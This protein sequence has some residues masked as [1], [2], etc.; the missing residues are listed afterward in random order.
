MTTKIEQA[1][2]TITGDCQTGKSYLLGLTAVDCARRGGRV[3]YQTEDR[4]MLK[5]RFDDL[6]QLAHDSLDLP[7]RVFL[8]NG[9]ERIEWA[10]GGRIVFNGDGRGMTIDLHILDDTEVG[11]AHPTA[12]RVMKA[13][14]G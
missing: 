14:L 2:I 7:S 4:R 12:T 6:Q 1:T 8:A 9:D 3:L 13:V 11:M 5:A 10:N